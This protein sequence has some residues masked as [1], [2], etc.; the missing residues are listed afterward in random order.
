MGQIP[1]QPAL[2]QYDDEPLPQ[3]GNLGKGSFA[4]GTNEC[5]SEHQ[6]GVSRD[7]DAQPGEQVSLHHQQLQSV[8][9][10]KVVSPSNGPAS[11]DI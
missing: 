1:E 10:T 2:F 6:R 8:F 3:S 4:R 5:G 7:P 11:Q 9:T